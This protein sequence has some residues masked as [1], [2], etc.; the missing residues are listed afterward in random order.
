MTTSYQQLI[1]KTTQKLHKILRGISILGLATIL[2]LTG[3]TLTG[4]SKAMQEAQDNID[5][6]VTAV[7]NN[8]EYAQ[9]L[10]GNAQ[11]SDFT[12]LCADV[13]KENNN[14][15]NVDINGIVNVTNEN[16]K[17]AYTTLESN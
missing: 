10:C 12:F 13:A 17:A 7:L 1:V 15:Y 11:F 5:Y 6:S 2:A 14:K 3:G 9:Q 16:T 4:C 8:D